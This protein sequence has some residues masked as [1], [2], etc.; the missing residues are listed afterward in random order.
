MN[1]RKYRA[2]LYTAV[3]LMAVALLS[4]SANVYFIFFGKSDIQTAAGFA[5]LEFTGAEE[6]LMREDLADHV[7]AYQKL[8]EFPL[9]NGI[10]PALRFNPFPA[11]WNTPK[12]LYA[13]VELALPEINAPANIEDLAFAS[14]TELAAL[15]KTKQIT[16]LALTEMYLSRLKK[17]D[18]ELKCVITLTEELA[19]EQARQA[20]MEISQG[21]YRGL[22]HGI[23][24]GL[25]DLLAVKGYKTTWGAMPYKDQVID[26]DATVVEKLREAGAVLL[27]KLSVGALAWGD[28]WFGGQTLNPWDKKQGSSGSSAGP[29]AT[30]A[31]GL[32]PFAIGTETWGSII[33]PSLRCGVTGLRPTFGRVSRYGAMALSWSMDKIGPICRS[34]EDC[35]LV[36]SAMYGPDNKDLSVHSAP[37][38]WPVNTDIKTLR[39]GYLKSAFDSQYD[40]KANDQAVLD[41]FRGLGIE[42]VP[43]ELPDFPVEAL[44]FILS[45]EAAAAFDELTRSGK[46]D[47]M[48][49]QE[50]FAWPNVFRTSRLIPAVEYINANRYRYLLLEKMTRLFESV[51]VFLAPADV[52]NNLLLTNLTGHPSIIVPNG[53]DK[54]NHPTGVTFTANLLEEEKLLAVARAFQQATEHHKKYPKL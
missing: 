51:D 43:V 13:K 4:V 36:L 52:G 27:G 45:A 32:A 29:A 49:R 3:A 6:K 19:R 42:L 22:L 54:E 12:S 33:S 5:G 21:K 34:A 50:R 2:W 20:D 47:L 10:A 17:Y 53:F 24:Y 26:T 37:F 48:V 16:S 1:N 9:D 18:G 31:A 41:I 11:V 40:N 38:S 28:V 30:V 15:I 23:P 39:I 25:K 14:L 8:R 44:S 46:D 7:K 35:G